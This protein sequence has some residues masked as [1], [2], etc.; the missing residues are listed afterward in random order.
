[1]AGGCWAEPNID[2]AAAILKRLIENPEERMALGLRA[3]A[4]I[5][6]QFSSRVWLE[7]V[8]RHLFEGEVSV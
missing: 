2:H 8:L 6:V 4:R 7:T 3:Q 5:N 1:M